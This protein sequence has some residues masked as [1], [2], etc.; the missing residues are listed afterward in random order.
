ME[1]MKLFGKGIDER[2]SIELS[3]VEAVLVTEDGE[4]VKM[5]IHLHTSDKNKLRIGLL[6]KSTEDC[7][8]LDINI[9]RGTF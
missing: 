9:L 2:Q 8:I 4:E 7:Q 1:V 3:R 5:N 6:G